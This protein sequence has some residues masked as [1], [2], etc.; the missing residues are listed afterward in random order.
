MLKTIP[1]WWAGRL[2]QLGHTH[3]P[4][5]W[6]AGRT[7]VVCDSHSDIIIENMAKW[8]TLTKISSVGPASIDSSTSYPNTSIFRR[9]KSGFGAMVLFIT[10]KENMSRHECGH[11][12]VCSTITT[13]PPITIYL[14]T[15]ME[16]V[17]LKKRFWRIRGS[18]RWW[19]R[20]YQ[21]PSVILATANEWRSCQ[22]AKR[23][24]EIL[25]K[26]TTWSYGLQ[27]NNRA[28]PDVGRTLAGRG[29]MQRFSLPRP[30][31]LM[32]ERRRAETRCAGRKWERGAAAI[33]G[34]KMD[35]RREGRISSKSHKHGGCA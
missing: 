1:L 12:W 32:M 29:Q 27:K 15:E 10:H 4:K 33:T 31:H 22:K 13:S 6:L 16:T 2:E 30:G 23:G 26:H 34:E 17:A 19:I 5:F 8:N 20:R 24:T 7:V 3:K 11:V 35:R 28:H 18:W 21:S 25:H 9:R 14:G